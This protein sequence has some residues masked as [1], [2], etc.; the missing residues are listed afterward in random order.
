[1]IASRNDEGM[2]LTLALIVNAALVAG[3]VTTLYLVMRIPFRL[4]D[5]N[6]MGVVSMPT[7]DERELSQAS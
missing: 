2:T 6:L 7:S 1:M 3:V 5:P 4:R